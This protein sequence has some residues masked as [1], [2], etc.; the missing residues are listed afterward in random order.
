M[1]MDHSVGRIRVLLLVD[2]IPLIVRHA[3][4]EQIRKSK[5]ERSLSLYLL[6]LYRRATDLSQPL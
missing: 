6:R 5:A 4:R 1:T 2:T 3:S